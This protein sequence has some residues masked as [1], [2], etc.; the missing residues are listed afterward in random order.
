MIVALIGA[1][2]VGLLTLGSSVAAVA[3]PAPTPPPT[4]NSTEP[5]ASPES[6]QSTGPTTLAPTITSPAPG[7]FVG[8]GTT[9]ISGTGEVGREI[10]LL[11]P[12]SDQDPLCFAVVDAAAVWS[13]TAVSLPS[14]PDVR[15]RVVVT[16]APESAAEQTI[17]VLSAPVVT[18]GPTGL[19]LTNGTV[20]GSGY[21][22]ASVV[23]SL[24]GGKRCTATADASGAWSCTFTGNV[25]GGAVSVSASQ[26]TSY[27]APSWSNASAPVSLDF[28]L[29]RPTA[30]IVSAPVGGDR[31]PLS[32]TTY[33]GSGED[34]A[35]VTVFSGAYSV[36]S[37]VVVSGSWSCF[38]GGVAAGSHQVIAV[39][40]D[41]A[42]NLGPGSP[43]VEVLFGPAAAATPDTTGPGAPIPT[44]GATAPPASSAPAPES[45]V[46]GA[47]GQEPPHPQ[48]SSPSALLP[49][50]VPGGW[51]DPTL[52]A[53]AVPAPWS[54]S[55]VS[56]VQA[57]FLAF[58]ALLLLCVP[59]RLLAGTVSRARN[60][61]PFWQTVS[62]AGRNRS[63][64][65]FET[66]PDLPLNRWLVA[67]A[68]VTAAAT[69]VM[70]SGPV[71]SQ[72]AYLRLLLAVMAALVVVNAVGT[73]V[74]L[75]WSSRVWCERA[76]VTFLPRYLLLVAATAL[77]SRAFEI[78]PALVFGLLGSVAA[79]PGLPGRRRGQLAAL[80]AGSLIALALLGWL[81]LGLLPQASGFLS[82]FAAEIATSVVLAA[83]GSAALV[84]IPIGRTSGRSILSWSPP[85]WAAL[86]VLAFTIMFGV[87][88]P[89]GLFWPGDGGVSLWWAGAGVFAALSVA[90]W[91]WQRF[92][93]P[94]RH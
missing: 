54:T 72:P 4:P 27:S 85:I 25:A 66:A 80:R 36:C 69:L 16:G 67:G 34:D 89:A 2:T 48:A 62:I 52:F 49:A 79:A 77:A 40:R 5:T 37:A 70:L 43:G 3:V 51:N 7:S 13:C 50:P 6:T 87:L 76:S 45:T 82:A 35:T 46:P 29:D 64:V 10:Q 14:G 93:V 75:W 60:G 38:A 88:S 58:G 22:A 12:V 65:E 73:L 57:A 26:Q 78:H 19:A 84:L 28:D 81:T 31:V 8:S 41:P 11:S 24:A 1:L 23:V 53:T 17:A 86:T 63:R 56:W 90:A 33:S 83:I 55:P 15:L 47:P 71:S 61:R 92:V 91:A 59:A 21:P 68:A 39:Q 18:G 94:A 30:P 9:T 42:G 74:P 20:R 32:G 44:M